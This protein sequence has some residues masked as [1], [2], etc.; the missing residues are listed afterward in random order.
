MR[1]F[2]HRRS[3]REMQWGEALAPVLQRTIPERA[4]T[5]QCVADLLGITL[6]GKLRDDLASIRRGEP[7]FIG[8]MLDLADVLRVPLV[9]SLV[10]EKPLQVA[11]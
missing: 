2:Q 11:A 5:N 3:R 1:G 9:P 6:H 4:L 10:F 7:I 8:R